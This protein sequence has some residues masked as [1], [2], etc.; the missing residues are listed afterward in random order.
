[1]E[2]STRGRILD[3]ALELLGTRGASAFSARAVEDVAGVPHGSVRHHFGDAAGLRRAMVDRL[4]ELDLEDAAAR[5]LA[6]IA[7]WLGEH[8]ARTAARYELMLMSLGEPPLGEALVRGRDAATATAAAAI[9][10]P[11]ERAAGLVAAVDGLV[12]DTM[13]R[14]R[15]EVDPAAFRVLAAGFLGEDVAAALARGAPG[16]AD[17]P[18]G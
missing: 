18:R 1:M 9:G 16:P 7:S 17:P 11:A 15:R 10:I 6:T 8:R 3:G 13:L 14:G 5:P 12:L 2:K 4:L